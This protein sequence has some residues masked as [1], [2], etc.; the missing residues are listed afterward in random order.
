MAALAITA[1]ATHPSTCKRGE[2]MNLPISLRRVTT[3]IMAA[4]IGTAIQNS[5]LM[6][7]IG[8]ID[9]NPD[10]S[11]TADYGIEPDRF[12]R[13]MLQAA[14]PAIRLPYCICGGPGKHRHGQKSGPNYAKAEQEKRKTTCHGLERL[15]GPDAKA[16]CATHKTLSL[17]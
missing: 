1:A 17:V 13:L 9:T 14:F 3:A 11:R 10:Q 2:A 4:M 12:P 6:G 15:S 16:A 5:A 7:S 8:P